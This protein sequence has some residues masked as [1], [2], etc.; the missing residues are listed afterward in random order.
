MSF[1][2]LM[3]ETDGLRVGDSEREAVAAELRDV[4]GDLSPVPPVRGHVDLR[5]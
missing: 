5:L 3:A 2:D 4:V 1:D